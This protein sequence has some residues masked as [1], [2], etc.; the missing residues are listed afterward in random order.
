MVEDLVERN[1][2]EVEH[3]ENYFVIIPSGMNREGPK[4]KYLLSKKNLHHV[5][6]LNLKFHLE[7]GHK[8]TPYYNLKQPH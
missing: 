4:G 3:L 8:N 7:I 6:S 1:H 5:L 2:A